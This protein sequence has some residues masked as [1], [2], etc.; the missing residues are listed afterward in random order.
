MR[1]YLA[2]LIFLGIIICLSSAQKEAPLWPEHFSI[3]YQ[4]TGDS[5]KL[6]TTAKIWYDYT[7]Q[8][9]RT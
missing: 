8:H 9:F 5:G 3:G 4:F 1:S 6:N 2:S 7:N